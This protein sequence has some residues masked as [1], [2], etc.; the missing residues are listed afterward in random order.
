MVGKEMQ[1]AEMKKFL[2]M[3]S[4][5]VEKLEMVID[6]GAHMQNVPEDAICTEIEGCASRAEICRKGNNF[7][8]R[9]DS[10][11]VKG[12]VAIITAMVDGKKTEEIKKMDLK[13]EF[14]SLNIN[15]GTGRLGGVNSMISFLQNL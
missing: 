14:A 8:G 2:L 9:A 13:A 12:I 10:A 7:Y 6:F 4:N 1:Y 5:P 15:L 11:L 3:T